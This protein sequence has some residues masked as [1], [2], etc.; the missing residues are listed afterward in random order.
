MSPLWR[1]EVG[2][3]VAPRRILLVRMKRGLRP[4][5]LAERSILIDA[6]EP[7]RW[8]P[9]LD[10]LDNCLRDAQWHGANARL[11]IADH[12]ARYATVPWTD[13]ISGEAERLA[14]A[15]MCMANTF[16]DLVAQW[17]VTVSESAPGKLQVACGMPNDLL[18]RLRLA[19]EGARLRIRSVQPYLVAAFNSWRH[20]MPGTGAWFVTLDEG[21][22]AAVHFTNAAWDCV[23][24]VR[25]GG[26][27]EVE[28]KRLQTFGRLART[29]DIPSP[30]YVDA[31]RWLR[32]KAP[33]R[34]RD[35]IWLDDGVEGPDADGISLMQRMYA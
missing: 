35:F 25:I 13:Q 21:S 8:E 1:D 17:H 29:S 12:W 31:P 27:W 18:S 15:R 26:D 9:A 22:L 19:C 3:F 34:V 24:S 16:G 7:G 6:R 14:H 32:D 28:L 30:V 4:Q 33:G 2:V 23:R 11:I 10:T 20:A 5:R